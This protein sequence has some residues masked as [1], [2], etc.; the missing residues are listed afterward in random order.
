MLLLVFFYRS[1]SSPGV[2]GMNKSEDS[3]EPASSNA[4]T[5]RRNELD[6]VPLPR[7]RTTAMEQRIV[8]KGNNK[9]VFTSSHFFI[10]KFLVKLQNQ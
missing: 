10:L 8:A 7:E 4:C 3:S 5:V 1:R 2:S 6:S 9:Y